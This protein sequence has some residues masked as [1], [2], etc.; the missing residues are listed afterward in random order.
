MTKLSQSMV[1]C[2]IDP[3]QTIAIRHAILWPDKPAEFCILP[4]DMQGLHYGVFYQACLVTVASVY[5]KGKHARLRKFATLGDFQGKGCG[6]AL[7][8]YIIEEL[9][10]IKI[11]SLWCDARLTAVAFYNRLG[12]EVEEPP[13]LKHGVAYCRMTKRFDL[14]SPEENPC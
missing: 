13:F 12:F 9:T 11:E 3:E 8:R 1:V 10:A 7:I 14:T 4:D 5:I 2:K 6:T